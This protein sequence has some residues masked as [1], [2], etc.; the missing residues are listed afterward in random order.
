[1]ECLSY[2]VY[3][4]ESCYKNTII[5]RFYT[6]YI[7]NVKILLMILYSAIDMYNSI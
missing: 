6:I 3:F 7:F 4:Y 1:M 5:F 2:D